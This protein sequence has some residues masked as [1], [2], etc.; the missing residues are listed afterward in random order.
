MSQATSPS[1]PATTAQAP[2]PTTAPRAP[3]ALSPE[4]LKNVGGGLPRGGWQSEAA[5]T[6]ATSK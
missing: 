6:S 5:P 1:T 3:V 4:Q 2:L